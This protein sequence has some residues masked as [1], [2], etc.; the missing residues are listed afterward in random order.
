MQYADLAQSDLLADKVNVNLDMLGA[1]MMNRICRH[2]DCT[3]I[4]P[5]NDSRTS[6]RDVELLK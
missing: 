2:V 6:N 3:H 5:L 1:S 4:V